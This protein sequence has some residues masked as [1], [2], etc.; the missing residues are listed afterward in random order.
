MNVLLLDVYPEL[1]FRISKDTNGGYGTV[2][3]F[4]NGFV[5]RLLSSIVAKEIDWPP[6]DLMYTG[7][8]IR[9]SG[10]DVS[11]SRNLNDC[12]FDSFDLVIMSSSIVAHE[13]EIEAIRHIEPSG[14]QVCVIGSFVTSEFQPYLD[15][16]AAVIVGE[17]ESFFQRNKAETLLGI[18]NKAFCE[19]T[20]VDVNT[21]PIPAWDL[22]LEKHIL[23]FG[24]FSMSKRM[25]PMLA[26]R[27]CPYNC[28]EY[29]TY[30]LQQG[31]AVRNRDASLIVDEMEYWATNNNCD[32][33]IFRDPVFS[34][35]RSHTVEL[36]R[37]LI[38]RKC[39][40]KFLMETHLKN[41]DNDLLE[42]LIEAG[43]L[44]MKVGIETINSDLLNNNKRYSLESDVQKELISHIESRGVQVVAH[45][46]VGMPGETYSSFDQTIQYAN[47]L[48]TLIAQFSVFT[49]YP[50]TPIF[51]SYENSIT[52][53][54]FEDFTQ[55][56]LVFE[57][58]N[59]TNADIDK[60]LSKAYNSYYIRIKSLIKYIKYQ[61]LGFLR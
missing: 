39:K 25:I 33:F 38:K 4:G 46:M 40:F 13:T 5:S 47:S 12:N 17:P 58:D 11:Y 27:G 14:T 42:L 2:N 54:N 20:R 51:S 48:N 45:Y 24:L 55:Y 6:M 28:Q 50:G 23:K 31:R 36:C 1:P 35:N 18:G 37:E 30:P 3:N 56:Q 22:F 29:C 49:P 41:I 16:G 19:E 44:V 10:N 57:H 59:L 43:L 7:S 34:L 21:L 60:M 15:A 26:T 9:E 8:I 32:L 61:I 53:K 52:A